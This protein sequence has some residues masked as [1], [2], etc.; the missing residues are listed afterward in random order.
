MLRLG[1]YRTVFSGPMPSRT[2]TVLSFL[3]HFYRVNVGL[4]RRGQ[5]R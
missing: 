2:V 4:G 3:K 1:I 5:F